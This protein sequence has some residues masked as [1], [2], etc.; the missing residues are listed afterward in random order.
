MRRLHTVFLVLGLLLG[1]AISAAVTLAQSPS[2]SAYLPDILPLGH[3]ACF[4]IDG[5]GTLDLSTL[6]ERFAN[7]PR[8]AA[9][10]KTL[11]WV[12]GAYRQFGCDAPPAGSAGWIDMS[13]HQF[14]DAASAAAA[15][16]FFADARA[17][18]TKLQ[19]APAASLGESSAALAG[20]ASNGTEYTLYASQGPLLFRVT[21]V[22]P[23]GTP[24]ADVEQVMSGLL[25]GS[26]VVELH[27]EQSRGAPVSPPTFPPSYPTS[28][29]PAFVILDL[30]T[31]SGNSSFARDINRRGQVLWAWGTTRYPMS[32]TYSD[33]HYVV[34][35]QGMSTD[36]TPLGMDYAIAINDLGMILGSTRDR[37]LLY[38]PDSGTVEPLPGF[39]QDAYPSDLND[40]GI[41]TGNVGGRPVIADGSRLVEIPLPP[42]YDYLGPEAINEAGDVAAT[43]RLSRTD[44]SLQRAVLFADGVETVLNPAPG[45]SSS[46]SIDLNDVGQLV[47]NPGVFGMHS[48]H[49]YGRAFLYD[50]RTG[51]TTD[52]GT[53]AGYQNSVAT[54]INTVGQVVGYAWLPD[55]EGD[56]IRRAYLYDHRTGVMTDLNQLIPP[57]SGWQVL[58]AF[59]I[60][61]AGQ[62][63]GQGLISGE[64]HGFV[65]TPSR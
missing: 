2:P 5:D 65:L 64:M 33:L 43:A 8:A 49:E 52:I 27:E 18:G 1:S 7:I 40:L 41:V 20:P 31:G 50:H 38:W 54:A 10:L 55:N 11:G 56:L 35:W 44:D 48:M 60:S 47:G 15:V 63:V 12:T 16:P 45:S 19:T 30:G 42:G 28:T 57:G 22:A 46:S 53:L 21:G 13:V 23:V 36:L 61:D 51:I 39:E 34:S 59:D 3:A 37:G 62:I 9:E 26:E 25:L 14:G 58:D 24:K 32:E 17:L 4:R 29:D 6:V